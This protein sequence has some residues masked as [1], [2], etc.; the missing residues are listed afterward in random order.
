MVRIVDLPTNLNFI[1]IILEFTWNGNNN[2]SL[3][4]PYIAKVKTT[5]KVK[6]YEYGQRGHQGNTS[7]GGNRE[8]HRSDKKKVTYAGYISADALNAIDE[9]TTAVLDKN[10]VDY[11]KALVN[12]FI[13]MKKEE[14]YYMIV[15]GDYWMIMAVDDDSMTFTDLDNDITKVTVDETFLTVLQNH[16]QISKIIVD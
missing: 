16:R 1:N 3:Q 4:F 5:T 11:P 6:S 13:E 2:Y 14:R 9:D 12:N 7:S 10:G 15:N 8:V